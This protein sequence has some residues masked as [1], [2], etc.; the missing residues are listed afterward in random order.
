MPTPYH[1]ATLLSRQP[2]AWQPPHRRPGHTG[3]SLW[4]FLLAL[5]LLVLSHWAVYHL[6]RQA[7]QAAHQVELQAAAV[8]R[9]NAATQASEQRRAAEAYL[10]AS[11]AQSIATL[12][13]E[14]ARAQKDRDALAARLRAG[15]VRVSVPVLRCGSAGPSGSADP[16]G[17]AAEPTR[18]EL[19]P[20][21]AQS[22]DRIAGDG[23]DAIRELNT[24][25]SRYTAAR[26]AVMQACH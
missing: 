10:A 23:D 21:V 7:D 17:S 16:A 22:L 2:A 11:A 4:P 13:Q 5:A 20:E 15:T 9:A 14:K 19:A 24:C 1:P 3:T 26:A 8:R 12:T 18:A 6:T 25:I